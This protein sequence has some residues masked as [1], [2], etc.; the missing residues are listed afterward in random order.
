MAV[1]FYSPVHIISRGITKSYSKMFSLLRKGLFPKYLRCLHL[2]Q[3]HLSKRLFITLSTLFY[4]IIS[5]PLTLT[6]RKITELLIIQSYCIV[7]VCVFIFVCVGT[8]KVNTQQ[9]L[10]AWTNDY[11]C[12]LNG[13]TL[14]TWIAVNQIILKLLF[15][16][17][18]LSN[19]NCHRQVTGHYNSLQYI[20]I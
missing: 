12:I 17:H 7:R 18:T 2:S 16:I 4:W 6:M 8:D 13:F 11:L 15:F 14:A 19:I 10:N 5:L 3:H 1:Y 9:L 20:W